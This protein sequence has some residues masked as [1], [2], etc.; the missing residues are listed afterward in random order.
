M[1]DK[2]K[3]DVK[4]PRARTDRVVSFLTSRTPAPHRARAVVTARQVPVQRDARSELRAA[5]GAETIPVLVASDDVARGEEAV[6]AYLD[7]HYREPPGAASQRERAAGLRRNELD[8]ACL[9]LAAAADRAQ[10]PSSLR[11]PVTTTQVHRGWPARDAA[12]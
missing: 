5:T 10:R 6:L 8:R 11:G 7:D 2:E 12:S 1:R 4:K 3:D 9:E